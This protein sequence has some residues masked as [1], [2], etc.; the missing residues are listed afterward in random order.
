[1]NGLI[2]HVAVDTLMSTFLIMVNV[3]LEGLSTMTKYF[4]GFYQLQNNLDTDTISRSIRILKPKVTVFLIKLED[5][6][7]FFAFF[8]LTLHSY[9]LY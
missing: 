1:M 5:S 2:S 9:R 7:S 3:H 6:T 8:I 4:L